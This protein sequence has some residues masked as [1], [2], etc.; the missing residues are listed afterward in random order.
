ME[1][2]N[3][4]TQNQ[5]PLIKKQKSSKVLKEE[6]PKYTI[7]ETHLKPGAY[8]RG[9][10]QWH[11]HC[12]YVC[13]ETNASIKISD[14]IAGCAVQH[15]YGWLGSQ[16]KEGMIEVLKDCVKSL[17]SGVGLVTCQVGSN[18]MGSLLVKGLLELGFVDHEYN[19]YQHHKRG[20]EQGH[21]FTLTIKK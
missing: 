15:L 10:H 5:Q 7:T 16:N 21:F 12:K 13:V 11:K 6:K 19:N 1:R 18:Y 17:S 9:Y 3:F 2:I 20:G 14:S 4:K 8:E